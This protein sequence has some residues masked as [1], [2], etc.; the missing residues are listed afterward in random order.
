ME[1]DEL[2]RAWQSQERGR[3]ITVDADLVLNLVRRNDRNFRCGIF[4]RDVR[5][6]GAA[7]FLVA[8]LTYFGVSAHLWA[9]FPMAAAGLFVGLFLLGDR[10]RMKWKTTT[11]GD[12][13]VACA[14]TSL[15]EVEH[16]IW[17]LTNVAWSCLLPIWVG[18]M[19][20]VGFFGFKFWGVEHLG[21]GWRTGIYVGM[22]GF[23]LV[24]TAFVYGVY[25]WNQRAIR[26]ELQPRK[27]ELQ[28]LLENLKAS[29]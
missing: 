27:Q 26:T 21:W 1:A 20:L 2:Q 23:V 9:C 29:D 19:I 18:I 13:L 8:F 15:A 11:P 24:Y 12:T 17:L 28:T 22:V 4:W 25:R 5:E 16:Q 7:L 10:L 14:E 3:Q 6:V